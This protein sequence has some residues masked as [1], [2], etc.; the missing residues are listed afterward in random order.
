MKD[1]IG[2]FIIGALCIVLGVLNMRGNVSSIHA[3]HRRRVSQEDLLSFGRGV[4]LGTVIAG[5]SI[6]L[7][8][9]FFALSQAFEG[10]WLTITG[11]A[12]LIVGLVVGLGISLYT[13]IKYNKGIF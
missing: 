13:I 1:F 11:A 6:I 10:A 12:V 5:G 4:G 2:A 3:Y 9:A 8:G 7:W